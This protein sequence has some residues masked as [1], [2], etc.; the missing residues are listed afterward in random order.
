[1]NIKVSVLLVLVVVFSSCRKEYVLLN[2][3]SSPR[4]EVAGNQK[5]NSEN[6][7]ET[8]VGGARGVSG[9]TSKRNEDNFSTKEIT[10]KEES[11]IENQK[12][13]AISFLAL[14]KDIKRIKKIKREKKEMNPTLSR[15]L[16]MTIPGGLAVILGIAL[17]SVAPTGLF[18]FAFSLV[19]LVGFV[20][21]ILYW[22]NPK[23]KM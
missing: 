15:A 19:F 8:I 21:L 22:A 9:I 1:M 2:H 12:A 11:E 14:K 16:W 3:S 7:V 6:L 5:E 17:Y 13:T 18:I 10:S 20:S 4:E 23:P